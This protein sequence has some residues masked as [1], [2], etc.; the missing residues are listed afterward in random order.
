MTLW[1]LPCCYDACT[2]ESSCRYCVSSL[3]I[4][5][6]SLSLLFANLDSFEMTAQ[7]IRISW[8]E[9]RAEQNDAS[10]FEPGRFLDDARD[11]IPIK[12]GFHYPS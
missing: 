8:D 1:L 9:Y 12:V 7:D 2:A 5:S 10:G 3:F 4:S 6:D 11:R